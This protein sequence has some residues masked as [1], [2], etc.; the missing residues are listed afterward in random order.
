M[1]KQAIIQAGGKGTRLGKLTEQTPKPLVEVAGKSLLEY[2]LDWCRD[3]SLQ[4]VFIVVNYLSERIEAF[5]EKKRKKYPGMQIRC[6]HEEQALG[7]AG[8]LP[9]LS[10]ELDDEF[11]LLYGDVL[12][13]IDLDRMLGFHSTKKADASLVLHPNDHPYDSDL[14]V[15][16]EDER[17]RAFLSKPHAEGL[18]YRNL[19]NAALYLLSKTII[20]DIPKGEASDFGK[21]IF[22]KAVQKRKI[23]GYSTPEF[24]KDMGTPDR[25]DAV[26]KAV[27][28]GKVK[29]RNLRCRQKAIFLDRDGVLNYDTDL[30]HRPED[31]TLYPYTADSL[32]RI[33]ASDYLS[34]ITTNQSVIAR[35]L[36]DIEGLREIHDKMETELGHEGAFVDAI[37][38][39]PHHP[40][41]GFP[42]ENAAFKKKCSCRKPSP[43]MIMQA[44]ERFHINL[45]KS[46]MIG[47]SERDILAGKAAGVRTIGLKTGHG[48]KKSRTEPDLF[49]SNLTEAVNHILDRPYE[50]LVEEILHK[51]PE[52]GSGHILLLGG[53][54]RTGKTHLSREIE[55]ALEEEGISC[56]T[57]HL[58]D[59][60][61]PKE[62]RPTDP[63]VFA[64]FNFTQIQSDLSS[65][66]EG[67]RVE[68]Q[69]YRRHPD[70]P[71]VPVCYQY[72]GQQVILVEGI[73]ALADAEWRKMA[74]LKIFTHCD[75]TV[76]EERIKTFYRWKGHTDDSID[77][78][79]QQ[80]LV[81]EYEVV[82]QMALHA[83]ILHSTG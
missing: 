34:V 44:T 47:D 72:E 70:R 16:D 64:N 21:D 3:H 24:L 76:H 82:D 17:V 12:F 30:I 6:V 23:Y 68:L 14:V 55:W 7:T 53:N 10:E 60:I 57:I 67:Q 51:L 1:L 25:R 41:G 73:L 15:T 45:K 39:C 18:R 33:N 80:R 29:R 58:D 49:F 5:L 32:K 74:H 46:W 27:L 79:Y 83:D 61:L 50:K 40:D 28:S 20:E 62:E 77:Q 26:E 31:F 11:L 52:E 37:Y 2:Q 13:D 81:N 66:L 54:S 22:P 78:Q 59:W 71:S 9:Y 43:G 42:G 69:G 38:Y 4:E 75:R 36:T 19:V 65:I 63:D 56:F 35:N 8:I 48:L